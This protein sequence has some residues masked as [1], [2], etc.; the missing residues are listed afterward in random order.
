[1][2]QFLTGNNDDECNNED[3]TP[4]SILALG[5]FY[6]GIV[7]ERYE[8]DIPVTFIIMAD[9]ANNTFELLDFDQCPGC[10]LTELD[11]VMTENNWRPVAVEFCQ[12]EDEDFDL[13]DLF[14]L[15]DEPSENDI[16]LIKSMFKP[17][18]ETPPTK[19]AG[20]TPKEN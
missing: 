11:E 14:F 18:N 6:K 16:N 15:T 1:M 3:L 9:D 8:E 2:M 10:F 4:L 17:N 7:T 19:E 5:N 20:E 12:D 13:I